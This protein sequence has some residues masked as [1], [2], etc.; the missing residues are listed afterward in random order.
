MRQ[1]CQLK[2][3]I[4]IQVQGDKALEFLQGQ[5]TNNVYMN[6][7]SLLCNIKGRIIATLQIMHYESRV[8]LLLNQAT[9]PKTKSVLEKVA[10]LSKVSF[11]E[12]DIPVFGILEN[13]ASFITIDAKQIENLEMIPYSQWHLAR[14]LQQ[15]F[16]I[17]ENTI[18]L[19]LP[20]DLGLENLNWIDFKKG[21]YR[22]QEIIA[23]MHYLGKSKYHLTCIHEES[24]NS[25]TPGDK[26][27]ND[28]IELGVVVD[29]AQ[30]YI[31]ACTRK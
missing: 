27:M 26:I 17:Y 29:K 10:L 28:N 2:N 25:L 21:C 3:Y 1:Y 22:G 18:G 15:E 9:W 7:K 13:Q 5:F 19:F 14:I 31:L 12:K 16:E 24:L 4:C 23:R 20:H 8:F 30:G 6:N 11:E